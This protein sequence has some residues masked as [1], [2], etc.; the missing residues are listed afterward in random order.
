MTARWIVLLRQGARGGGVRWI[1]IFAA[2]AL[3]F[4]FVGNSAFADSL[5]SGETPGLVHGTTAPPVSVNVQSL[6]PAPPGGEALP[7]E[8]VRPHVQDSELLKLKKKRMEEGLLKP[9]TNV[10]ED[11]KDHPSSDTRKEGQP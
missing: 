4:G 2:A 5:R 1:P 6:E 8:T 9:T 7:S 3:A 10:I 11:S